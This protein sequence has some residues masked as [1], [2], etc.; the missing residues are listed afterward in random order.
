MDEQMKEKIEQLQSMESNLQQL[1]AKKQQFQ[2]QVVEIDSAVAE[3][4]KTNQAY[5]IIGNIMVAT[6]KDELTKDLSQ[7]KELL[8]LRVQTVEKQEKKLQDQAESLQ[9]EVLAGMKKE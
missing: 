9:K 4:E 7:K 2:S 3:L 8:D 1:L 5:K 6:D